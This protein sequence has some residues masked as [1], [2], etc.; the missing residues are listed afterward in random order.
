MTKD[1]EQSIFELAKEVETPT[2]LDEF[3]GELMAEMEQDPEWGER[4]LKDFLGGMSTFLE[5][6]FEGDNPPSWPL[7]ARILLTGFTYS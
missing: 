1:T 2:D 5:G 3:I 4:T 7:F 6:H